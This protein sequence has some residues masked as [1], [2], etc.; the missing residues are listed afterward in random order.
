MK[1]EI[2]EQMVQSW[3]LHHQQCQIVQTN[4]SISPL[5]NI[6]QS[7]IQDAYDFVK[8]VQDLLNATL[9]SE[10]VATLQE[11]V[12]EDFLEKYGYNEVEPEQGKAKKKSK[13]IKKLNIIKKSTAGQFI[14]QCEIDVVGVRLDDGIV[15]RVFL[16]DS[17]FHK[18]G[19]GYHDVVA[20]VI[21]KLIRAVL[22][23]NIIFG[24]S[25]DVTVAFVAPECRTSVKQD[26]EKV[27]NILQSILVGN[28]SKVVIEIYFNERFTNEIYEPLKKS[29]DKLNN[30]NDLFMR[31]LNLVQTAEQHLSK[32]P[33]KSGSTT[34]KPTPGAARKSAGS[35]PPILF[36]PNDPDDFRSE[37]IC[38]KRAEITWV[39]EDG[40][41]SVEFWRADGITDSS[42]IK[43]NIQSRSR[44]RN[45]TKSRG[46]DGL[47]EVHVK[48]L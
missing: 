5:R 26:I 48:V 45:S 41:R 43:G 37:L 22:V 27:V 36:T 10:T 20:T 3:L 6:S 28:L 7:D 30:D 16:V 1:I 47:V 21:K 17:A 32:V 13:A 40:T 19:L 42:N 34:A 25:V 24:G 31:A 8:K 23:A 29:T 4:W 9:A 35:A 38:R 12:D 44:W 2:C 33:A 46:K 11:S 39:Y 15:N 18:N 14:R